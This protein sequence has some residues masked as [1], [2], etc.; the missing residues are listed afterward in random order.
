[1]FR[2]LIWV[3]L[4]VGAG[5]FLSGALAA[6][7]PV[8]I[9][10]LVILA[11]VVGV[12]F[13][14]LRP[15]GI[16]RKEEVIDDWFS[17]IEGAQGK[18]EQMF[19]ETQ[20]ALR[21]SKAPHL[22]IRRRRLSPGVL[23]GIA[24]EQRDFLVVT[25]QLNMRLTPYQMFVGC[26]DYGNALVID[27]NLTFRP[28]LLQSLISL[29]LVKTTLPNPTVD[30]DLFDQQDLRAYVTIAHRSL[31]RA[32]ENLMQSLGQDTSRLDRRSRGFLGI[33]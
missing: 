22:D 9:A 29:L 32:V 16:L 19:N 3:F 7:M 25:H 8:T 30:L 10:G 23:R 14:M 24:G 26:R 6:S 20:T 11:I 28:T 5:L 12:L 13:V 4:L 2:V 33:S 27:W 15:G 17:L 1:M 31:L 18:A 21:E